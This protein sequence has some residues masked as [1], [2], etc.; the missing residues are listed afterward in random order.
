M[1]SSSPLSPRASFN[2]ARKASYER[3]SGGQSSADVS[4]LDGRSRNHSR[5][6]SVDRGARVAETGRLVPRNRVPSTTSGP[7]PSDLK[8]QTSAN[9]TGAKDEQGPT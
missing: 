6:G 4:P 2:L 9:G 5:V 1:L 7:G 8:S 3:V